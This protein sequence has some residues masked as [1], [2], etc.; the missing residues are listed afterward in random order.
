[1]RALKVTQLRDQLGARSLDTSGKKATLVER[2]L[3]A[4][5]IRPL[6][7]HKRVSIPAGTALAEVTIDMAAKLLRLPYSLGAHPTRGE[8]ITLHI[9]RFGPYLTLHSAPAAIEDG[10]PAVEGPPPAN[11]LCSIPTRFSFWDVDLPQAAALLDAKI[12]RDA[13]RTAGRKGTKAKA[14]ASSKTRTLTKAKAR[15]PAKARTSTKAS[16]PA[17]AKAKAVAS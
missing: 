8:D 2:L 14:K 10:E 5:D 4:D 11:V 17:K 9:G 1:M 6:V 7:P 12:V 13:A 3:Q 15:T 16:P